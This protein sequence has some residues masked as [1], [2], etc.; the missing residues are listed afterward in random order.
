MPEK[1]AVSIR[2]EVRG[3]FR[4]C[5][6]TRGGGGGVTVSIRFEVRGGF[7][8]LEETERGAQTV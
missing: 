1:R 8:R 3:G 7:R 2:F 6:R 4:P 5:P